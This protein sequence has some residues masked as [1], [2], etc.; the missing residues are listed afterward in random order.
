MS[1]SLADIA[2]SPTTIEF[3]GKTYFLREPDIVQCGEYTRHLESEAR[4]AVSRAVELPE[5]ERDRL[6]RGV[7]ADI[8]AKEYK[9][10]G[11]IA[12]KSLRTVDG[13][14][15]LLSIICRDQGMTF[16]IAKRYAN[17]RLSEIIAVMATTAAETDPKVRAQLPDILASLKLAPTFLATLLKSS[18]THLSVDQQT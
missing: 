4:A 1:E 5:S 10:G 18:P 12:T 9:Y 8:A 3:E 16:D 11:E 6:M 2:N 14:A 13:I 7:I 17:S 15:Q